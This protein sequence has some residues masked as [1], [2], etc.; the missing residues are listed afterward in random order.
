MQLVLPSKQNQ[1]LISYHLHWP[2]SV[3]TSHFSHGLTKI[4]SGPT[5]LLLLFATYNLFIVILSKCNSHQVT[6]LLQMPSHPNQ[7]PKSLQCPRVPYII[8]SPPS[9]PLHP[10]PSSS[11]FL[12]CTKHTPA[13]LGTWLSLSQILLLQIAAFLRHRPQTSSLPPFSL[14]LNVTFR[15]KVNIF[16]PEPDASPQSWLSAP[17]YS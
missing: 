15:R 1:G 12:E 8:C 6:L 13:L 2:C 5:S 14:C 4:A 10:F 9:F 7:K 16:N 3:W 17:D 11:L